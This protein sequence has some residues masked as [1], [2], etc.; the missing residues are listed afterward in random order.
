MSGPS[1]AMKTA[2]PPKVK[3][4]KLE[5]HDYPGNF[6]AVAENG[7]DAIVDT[8]RYA[9]AGSVFTVTVEEWPAGELEALREFDGW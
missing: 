5:N 6:L 8:V 4:W 1:K 3:V 9:E 2:F 7:L